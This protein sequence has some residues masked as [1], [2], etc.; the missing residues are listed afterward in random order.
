[1]LSSHKEILHGLE[2]LEHK[3]AEHDDQVLLIFEY[4]K[5]LEQIKLRELYQQNRKRIG[6]KQKNE[7]IYLHPGND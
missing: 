6:Y 7:G 3:L 1:M 2:K 4:L 5:H